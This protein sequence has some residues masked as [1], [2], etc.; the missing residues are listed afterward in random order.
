MFADFLFMVLKL[1]LLCVSLR[2]FSNKDGSCEK[3]CFG[4][5]G[6]HLNVSNSSNFLYISR[7]SIA[8]IYT[9]VSWWGKGSKG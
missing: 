6:T 3:S 8:Y 5:F 9:Y 7:R 4:N 2:G 1:L